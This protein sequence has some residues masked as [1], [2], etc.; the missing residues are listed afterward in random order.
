V[1][2]LLHDTAQSSYQYQ[3][4][5]S[6]VPTNLASLTLE[7]R[8]ADTTDTFQIKSTTKRAA[9]WFS[10]SYDDVPI[11]VYEYRL[12]D[13]NGNLIDLG[14]GQTSKVLEIRRGGQSL[15]PANPPVTT[16]YTPVIA[17]TLDRWGNVVSINDP[18]SA[19]LISNYRYDYLNRVIE[20]VKPETDIWNTS[21]TNLRDDGIANDRPTTRYFYDTRGLRIASIDPSGNIGG[22]RYDEAGRLI[23]EHPA[24][25]GTA[26]HSYD[27]VGREIA[28]SDPA[29]NITL[30]A[31]N[32]NDLLV[33]EQ[34]PE[35]TQTY[36]YDEVG[37][38]ITVK[39]D[40][41][42]TTRYFYDHRGNVV[43]TRL[44]LGGTDANTRYYT[45]AAYDAFGRKI[46][47]SNGNGDTQTWTYDY[48]GRLTDHVD[49]G[50]ANVDYAYNYAGQ[51]TLQTNTRGQNL[52]YG[53][54]E[55]G[56]LKRIVDNALHTE[57]YYE[58]DAAAHRTRERFR[59][60]LP[61]GDA[62][63][64]VRLTYDALGRLQRVKDNRYDLR[65]GYDAT[66]NRRR[67]Q[68]NYFDNQAQQQ[69]KD[70]WY[71]YDSMH[72]IVLSQGRR[73][74]GQIG[75][76]PDQ[77]IQ[78]GY[79]TAG[80][81]RSANF[82]EGGTFVQE[83]Y[84]YDGNN[85]LT[86]TSRNGALTSERRYDLA[87]R[88]KE[89]VAYASPGIFKDRQRSSYDANGWLL[90][91]ESFNRGNQ[92]T[93]TVRYDYSGAY[94]AVGNVLKYSIQVHPGS[95][96]TNTYTKEYAKFDSYQERVVHGTSTYLQPGDT[97]SF[98]DINGNLTRVEDR[99]GTNKNR[100]VITN[101]Q[102]RQARRLPHLPSRFGDAHARRRR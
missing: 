31:Y 39:N 67:V 48:F 45:A 73:E 75:I 76:T 49:F 28:R 60:L 72:R 33:R 78:L 100:D 102:G 65:Y 12:R 55:N 4:V 10:A 61:G 44:P 6:S 58:Y 62:Y 25:G 19:A 18:R 40:L 64:D 86:T 74:N 5:I 16:T 88:V 56:Q 90:R 54:Y 69:T 22:R 71:L 15:V 17:Q 97:T 63:Q 85:R 66:G 38:R 34:L 26:K 46:R 41:N 94:D 82:Y 36:T 95:P 11:G 51:L 35:V 1:E 80:N 13:G 92:P 14:A 101:T 23:S 8:C 84:N 96:Y 57:T 50:G 91:Q 37:N 29:G 52:S 70:Y 93:Q 77:G 83:T 27:A 30:L 7:Y 9:G 3:L 99:F 47:E 89:Y 59:N 32:R 98:Y 21:G 24:D 20:E 81:R 87:G 53:Y 2:L 79:D 43:M 42:E 68:S